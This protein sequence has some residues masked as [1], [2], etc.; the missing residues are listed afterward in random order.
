MEALLKSW[1]LRFVDQAALM[2]R[3][4]VARYSA[5][6]AK[7]RNTPHEHITLLCLNVQKNT[8]YGTLLDELI[9]IP[10]SR[11]AIDLAELPSPS[12]LCKAFNRLNMAVWCFLLNH[13]VTFHSTNDVV[14]I[15]ASG[16]DRGHASKHYTKRTKLTIQQLQVTLNSGSKSVCPI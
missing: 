6:F 5:K 16:F 4:T 15:D 9:L 11:S 7:R 12:I 10:R 14:G 3:R 1:L 2:S 13:S 8:I